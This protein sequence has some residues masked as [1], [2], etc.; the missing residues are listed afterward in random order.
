MT[1]PSILADTGVAILN[2]PAR[3]SLG[4]LARMASGPLERAGAE[5]AVAF[6]SYARGTADAW[7]DLDLVVVMETDLRPFE[8]ARLVGGLCAALPVALDLQVF[9]PEEFTRGLASGYDVFAA[10]SAEGKP[11]YARSAADR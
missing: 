8:R 11:F 5:R 4:D 1:R 3:W 6:G 9:N 10:I 7:S 2:E